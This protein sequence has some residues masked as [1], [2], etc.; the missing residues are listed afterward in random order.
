MEETPE[1]NNLNLDELIADA[2]GKLKEL[3][4]AQITVSEEA[5]PSLMDSSRETYKQLENTLYSI[6]ELIE[7]AKTYLSRAPDAESIESIASLVKAAQLLYRE[8]TEVYQKN[9][10]FKN[11]IEL[12]NLRFQHRLE[13]ENHKK[14]LK[15]E[16]MKE[17]NVI[18]NSEENAA[19]NTLSIIKALKNNP[20]QIVDNQ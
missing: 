11:A 10:D 15:A 20:P 13:L 3:K 16:L 9:Q 14:R 5:P 19:F 4:E 18:N 12:E 2:S 6:L 7:T 8:F 1:I 17:T